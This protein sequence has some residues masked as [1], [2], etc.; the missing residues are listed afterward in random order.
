MLWRFVRRI[1]TNFVL[2]ISCLSACSAHNAEKINL[3]SAVATA[4][5]AVAGTLVD[6][7]FDPQRV[8]IAEEQE[9]YTT[10]RCL[11]EDWEDERISAHARSIREKLVGRRYYVVRYPLPAPY[12][13]S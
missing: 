8:E 1:N 4:N 13:D 10:N 7:K 3:D 2:L 5:R 11:A 6:G 12:R 9:K